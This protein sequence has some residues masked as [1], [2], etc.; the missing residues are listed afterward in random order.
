A[1]FALVRFRAHHA[2]APADAS[3]NHGGSKSAGKPP[4]LIRTCAAVVAAVLI[5]ACSP[6]GAVPPSSPTAR[7]SA[8]T[9]GGTPACLASMLAF[10]TLAD[11]PS[12]PPGVDVVITAAVGNASGQPCAFPGR[13]VT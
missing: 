7:P 4:A 3:P 2:A 12:Y 9:A 5:A 11:Q 6:S 8:A 1:L 13:D 10:V